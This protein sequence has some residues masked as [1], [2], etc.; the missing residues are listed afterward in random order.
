[1][2]Y[3]AMEQKL[4]QFSDHIVDVQNRAQKIE[5]EIIEMTRD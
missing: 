3:R 5:E 4:G 1:M 2:T